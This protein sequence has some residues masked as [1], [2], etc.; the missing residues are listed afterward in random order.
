M[1]RRIYRDGLGVQ[2]PFWCDYCRLRIA[3]YE[4][5]ITDGEQKYHERCFLKFET[6]PRDDEPLRAPSLTLV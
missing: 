3:P 6:K 4:A 5:A 2:P 1:N